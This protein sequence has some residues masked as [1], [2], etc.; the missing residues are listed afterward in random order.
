[1][2]AARTEA[3]LQLS[4]WHGS[5]F[6]KQSWVGP[7]TMTVLRDGTFT[8]APD[9]AQGAHFV[10]KNGPSTIYRDRHQHIV[11]R[12]KVLQALVDAKVKQQIIASR[13]QHE[14]AARLYDAKVKEL[15]R[16]K[17]LP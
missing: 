12:E 16:A 4:Q 7:N 13:A 14:H 6:H 2:N 9:F 1:M 5:A 10:E 3:E 17:R 15:Q 11:S 8:M